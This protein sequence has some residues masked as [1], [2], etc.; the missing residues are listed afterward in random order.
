MDFG[1][2]WPLMNQQMVTVA[3]VQNIHI[4]IGFKFL[5]NR[6]II[7]VKRLARP[8]SVL[9]SKYARVYVFLTECLKICKDWFVFFQ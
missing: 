6:A 9:A 3:T 7:H 4:Y 8:V 2:F 1:L 5:C